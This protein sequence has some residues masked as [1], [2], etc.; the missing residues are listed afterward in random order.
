MLKQKNNL[1]AEQEEVRQTFATSLYAS[2]PVA[3]IKR[4]LSAHMQANVSAIEAII[5]AQAIKLERRLSFDKPS[6][7]CIGY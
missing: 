4:P 6:A 3:S 5:N 1:S 2:S 7:G